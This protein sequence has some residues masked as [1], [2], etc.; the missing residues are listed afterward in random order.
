MAIKSGIKQAFICLLLLL[1]FLVL[2][3]SLFLYFAPT[4]GGDPDHDSNARINA[5]PYFRNNEFTNLIRTKISTKSADDKPG[6]L[7]L[8]FPPADKN[9][10]TPIQSSS[11]KANQLENGKF[12]WFGHSTILFRLENTT[13]LIDPVFNRASPVPLF[14][15]P[16][17]TKYKYSIS[18]LPPADIIIIS[19]DHYDHLDHIA[20]AELA[21]TTK[22]FVVPL[23]VSGHLLRWGV[24]KEKIVEL[25]W[26]QSHKSGKLE[27][28]LTPARH[29]SGRSLTDQNTTLW[30]SW[31][32]RTNNTAVFYS[33]DS[34]YFDEFKKIGTIY[35]PFDIAFIENGAYD[36]SWAEIH[37]KPEQAVQAAI[38]LQT[39]LFFPVHWGKFDLAYHRWDEPIKR[40]ISAAEKHG[41]PTATPRI[42]QVFGLTAQSVPKQEINSQEM[43]GQEMYNRETK[44]WDRWWESQQ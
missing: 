25:D 37:M 3:V 42:G 4:F 15:K 14:G 33:G 22:M 5:S 7:S 31:V 40:A 2:S 35:G 32:I 12:V 38:D 18:E 9:P 23:G 27:L 19:H 28:V 30:G 36:N 10:V 6:I 44:R 26:Y 34:G 8:F 43:Y 20:I 17:E 39:K 13:V 24:P 1:V 29:F 41:I 11:F 16:F 21:S